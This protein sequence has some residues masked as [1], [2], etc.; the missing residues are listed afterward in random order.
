MVL[1]HF[2]L[3]FH[4]T[5]HCPAFATRWFSSVLPSMRIEIASDAGTVH[6]AKSFGRVAASGLY[7]GPSPRG[8]AANPKLCL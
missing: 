3:S 1:K 6:K 5:R 8:L 2:N 4:T 7:R